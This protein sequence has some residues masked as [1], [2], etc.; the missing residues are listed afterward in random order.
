MNT[1]YIYHT[2]PGTYHMQYSSRGQ[3][4]SPHTHLAIVSIRCAFASAATYLHVILS[5]DVA[6]RL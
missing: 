6:W 1:Q 2:I 5:L 3:L 4:A